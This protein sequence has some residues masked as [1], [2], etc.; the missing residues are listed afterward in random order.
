MIRRLP[1][2]RVITI[3]GGNT[4]M[5]SARTALRLGA[6]ESII[7][8]RRSRAEM[9]ARVEEIHHAEQEGV[10]F[11]LL[12]TPVAFHGKDGRV[13]ALECL[14]NELG[15]PDASGRR[16]P[17]PI[18]F[19]FQDRSRR[20]GDCHWSEPQPDHCQDH[21][22]TWERRHCRGR[23]HHHEDFQEGVFAAAT[24]SPAARQSSWPWTGKNR[25]QCHR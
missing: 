21:A 20:D 17:V 1:W 22:S 14:Q 25:R 24:S 8:Y 19:Q 4:A 13:N 9:P 5:D 11:N 10:K 6:K 2:Q 15:E 23:P 16:K 12:T 3:G 7:V 18:E